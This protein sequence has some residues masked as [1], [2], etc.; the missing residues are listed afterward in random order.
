MFSDTLTTVRT[1]G[2]C[3]HGGGEFAPEAASVRNT[4]MARYHLLRDL[5]HAGECQPNDM[6]TDV[7]TYLID[8]EKGLPYNVEA[9]GVR[10]GSHH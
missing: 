7:S 4:R 3:R 6:K 10:S 5:S 8:R 1:H 9:F 2:V